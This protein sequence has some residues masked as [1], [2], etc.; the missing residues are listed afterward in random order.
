MERKG[1]VFC[2]TPFH[3]SKSERQRCGHAIAHCPFNVQGGRSRSE[4][5]RGTSQRQWLES[6]PL[7]TSPQPQP[8]T[9]PSDEDSLV[10]LPPTPPSPSPVAHISLSLQA[11]D[12]N[13]AQQF[14]LQPDHCHDPTDAACPETTGASR[15]QPKD[16][17]HA[18][19]LLSLLSPHYFQKV[20]WP[21]GYLLQQPASLR[22]CS[23]NSP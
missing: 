18:A 20:G 21:P 7:P 22:C 6:G 16:S 11:C 19:E 3:C 15:P 17:I 10:T 8:H 1:G 14:P 2:R 5:P 4:C 9:L 23:V 13:L 12:P